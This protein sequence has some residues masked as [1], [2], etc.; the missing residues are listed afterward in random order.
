M[1]TGH[2]VPHQTLEVLGYGVVAVASSG[3]EQRAATLLVAH[4]D[5]VLARLEP[6]RQLEPRGGEVARL[7]RAAHDATVLEVK[8]ALQLVEPEPTPEV[9]VVLEDEVQVRRAG[10]GLRAFLGLVDEEPAAPCIGGFPPISAYLGAKKFLSKSPPSLL[11]FQPLDSVLPCTVEARADSGE[12]VVGALVVGAS[13]D[14]L[15]H[16]ID[17]RHEHR[18]SQVFRGL[19][20]RTLGQGTHE[21]ARQ[22]VK[23]VLALALVENE[24]HVQGLLKRPLDLGGE[25]RGFDR[26][27]YRVQVERA[28]RHRRDT[29][30]I[31]G[32]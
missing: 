1:D 13:A 6:V 24:A 27:A 18:L 31:F 7:G 16:A 2:A 32:S 5:A 30:K 3:Q 28:G 12:E 29:R 19:L 9:L 17:Q 11:F 15:F 4:V 22:A 10:A 25:A 8:Q 23:G 26:G 20:A 14:V 21:R